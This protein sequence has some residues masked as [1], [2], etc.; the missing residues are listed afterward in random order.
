M[1]AKSKSAQPQKRQPEQ[2]GVIVQVPSDAI[3]WSFAIRSISLPHMER[4]AAA[5]RVPAITV[6]EFLPRQYR[7]IDGYHRWRLAKDR[8]D[9]SVA[10]VVQ[11]FPKGEEGERTFDF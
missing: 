2:P 10:A 1:K 8:G 11:H 6:W 7:G 4:L 5:T 9:K 3:D